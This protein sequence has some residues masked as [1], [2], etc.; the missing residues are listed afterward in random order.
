MITYYD[1]T[2]YEYY[3]KP[4]PDKNL[5]MCVRITRHSDSGRLF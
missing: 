2:T 1:S 4:V 5:Q 3:N